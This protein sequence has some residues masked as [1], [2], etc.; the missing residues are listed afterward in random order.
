MYYYY[1]YLRAPPPAAFYGLWLLGR[2][3]EEVKGRLDTENFGHHSGSRWGRFG[4]LLVLSWAHF[5]VVFV[6]NQ[7]HPWC[8][9]QDTL[10]STGFDRFGR[11]LGPKLTPSWPPSWAQNWHSTSPK[12]QVLFWMDFWDSW[13]RFWTPF[14]VQNGIQKPT[15]DKIV[16]NLKNRFPCR[17]EVTVWCS[18]GVKN[19]CKLVFK[20]RHQFKRKQSSKNF[21]R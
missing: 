7:G 14:G 11:L 16:K 8:I 21:P 10:L 9:W 6:W 20:I 4:V 1:Y 3:W 2:V 18:K 5:G 13:V 12:F 19:Q 15:Q 17:R